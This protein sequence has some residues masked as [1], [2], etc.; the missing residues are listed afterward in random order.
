[1]T[2]RAVAVVG[3]TGAVGEELLA[4]LADRR[5]PVRE[6]RLFASAP[7]AGQRVRWGGRDHAVQPLAP[8][9]FAGLD[10]AFFAAGAEVASAWARAAAAAGVVAIDCSTAFRRDP[11]VPLVVPEVN[12]AALRGH[13]GLIANPNCST[14]LLTLALAPLHRAAGVRAAVVATYQAASGAGRP[15]I[16]ELR[17]GIAALA[18]GEALP[19]AVALPQ[20]LAGNLFPHVDA[21][22]EDGYTGEEDKLQEEARR[23]LGLPALRVDATCVRVPVERCHSEAV[24][25]QLERPLT[26]AAAAALLTAAPG[27]A[28]VDDPSAARYPTP[29]AQTGRDEVAVGRIRRGRVFEPGVTFWLVGDQLRKG[30]ALNAVQIAEAL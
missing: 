29:S 26:A 21:F 24:A 2:G 9:W 25:V 4:V 28:V 13:R 22:G 20:Q 12:A 8:G 18:R 16:D 14:I 19:P 5:F 10:L 6:L 30:A 23:I 17:A 11:A 27:L 3:A 15:G 1:V 7:C